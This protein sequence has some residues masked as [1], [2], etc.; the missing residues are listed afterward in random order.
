MGKGLVDFDDYFQGADTDTKIRNMNAM[1]QAHGG[2]PTPAC[3]F[4]AKV[5]SHSVP[6]DLWS[7]LSLIGG[8][9]LPTREFSRRPT[10]RYTGTGSQFRFPGTQT[11]QGYPK[12]GA[13]RDISVRG[14]QFSGGPSV[15]C[16]ERVV[17][18]DPAKVLWFTHFDD[19]GWNGFRSIWTGFVDG[20][21]IIGTSHMQA[22]SD[23]AIDWRGS[24]SALFGLDSVSFIDSSVQ[25]KDA[26]G[27]TVLA[28]AGKPMIRWGVSKGEIGR[29]MP[30]TRKDILA[31]LITTGG[32][33]RVH[34]LTPDAQDSDPCYGANIRIE[35]NA[36]GVLIT[37]CT[38]KGGMADPGKGAGGAAKNRG[39]I[40]VEQG[41]DVIIDHNVFLR[42]GPTAGPATT[43]LVF[44]GPGVSP[45]GIRVGLT[46]HVDYDGILAASKAGQYDLGDR[47]LRVVQAA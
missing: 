22:F 11:N 17:N 47:S 26:A 30:T 2:K 13:P 9:G 12:S 36:R 21:G 3:R 34:G 38:F 39:I 46:A 40:H 6:I 37:D 20:C 1:F 33:V 25:V 10:L 41:A 28:L 27:A 8:A 32:G 44:A 23:T 7:G 19:C 24:E 4:D 18:Y 31:L 14:L 16:I 29:C 45:L 5:Y 15:D 43:P 42:E 35:G